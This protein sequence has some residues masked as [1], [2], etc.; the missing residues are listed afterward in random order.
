[1]GIDINPVLDFARQIGTTNTIGRII[2]L[3]ISLA[4]LAIA[5]KPY[6]DYWVKNHSTNHRS[7]RREQRAIIDDPVK[8][9]LA[10]NLVVDSI[11]AHA[12]ENL[13]AD[14]AY[15]LQ[16]HNGIILSSGISAERISITNE[17]DKNGIAE[18]GFQRQPYSI[19]YFYKLM[20]RIMDGDTYV[21]DCTDLDV[22]LQHIMER[23]G[24]KQVIFKI[25]KGVV[26][27]TRI[28]G[29]LG[30]SSLHGFNFDKLTDEV[31]SKI[32]NLALQ[33]SGIIAGSY[34]VCKLCNKVKTCPKK[35]RDKNVK[36]NCLSYMPITLDPAKARSVISD[37]EINE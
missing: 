14:R 33:T 29:I 34:G 19:Q 7:P 20:A 30:L 12:L 26:N 23:S 36:N 16:F 9:N 13:G 1:M 4:V 21:G 8:E 6:F 24:A 2:F 17:M 35:K 5:L 10:I 27:N 11:L 28:I 18:T 37:G 15:V 25:M 31:E 32:A 3:V 22:E